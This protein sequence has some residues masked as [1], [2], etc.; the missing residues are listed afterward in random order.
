M[1]FPFKGFNLVF[2]QKALFRFI[3]TFW[4][5]LIYYLGI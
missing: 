4:T 1:R 2:V 5:I 3:Q